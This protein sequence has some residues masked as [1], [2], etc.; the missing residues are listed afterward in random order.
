MYFNFKK[1]GFYLKLND[2]ISFFEI[3]QGVELK[4]KIINNTTVKI[5]IDCT[6]NNNRKQMEGTLIFSKL[7]SFSFSGTYTT[8]CKTDLKD[9]RIPIEGEFNKYI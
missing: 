3:K 8:D 9:N 1:R 5:S 6:L 4:S 7:D 2:S